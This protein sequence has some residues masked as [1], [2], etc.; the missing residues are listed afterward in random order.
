[1]PLVSS[2]SLPNCNVDDIDDK[3]YEYVDRLNIIST[4]MID[5]PSLTSLT[6]STSSTSSTTIDSNTK[7]IIEKIIIEKEYKCY[8]RGFTIDDD[9][10]VVKF[11]GNNS[12]NQYNNVK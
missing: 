3:Y 12:N 11:L 8:L 5:I 6:S 10:N 9:D 1:M 7:S 4:V 2:V